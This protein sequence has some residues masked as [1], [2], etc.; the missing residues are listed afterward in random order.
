MTAAGDHTYRRVSAGS[1]PT[2]VVVPG[3]VGTG[4]YSAGQV[5]LSTTFVAEPDLGTFWHI[6]GWVVQGGALYRSGYS[7]LSGQPTDPPFLTRI[8]G[9]WT[10]FKAVEEAE[11]DEVEHAPPV[12]T[13]EYG[14]R[15]D[16]LL[17]R[18]QNNND[19]WRRNAGG[20]GFEAVKVMALISKTRT[21]DTFL[22]TTRGGGLYTIR[23]STAVPAN[24]TVTRVRNSTWQV[25]ETL[26]AVKCGVYGT[27]LL[28][29]DKD[30]QSGYLYAVG[31]ANGLSTV[32]QGLG[33]VQG[34][35]PDPVN[36]RW[37]FDFDP[38]NGA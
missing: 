24:F 6:V 2:M 8:G 5:R 17:V 29:I 19:V 7:V 28:G 31:H 30:T 4:I 18:W 11:Y 13:Y 1:P 25:F 15:N 22:A 34:T 9:G 16:G 10:D 35:F 26:L 3:R 37:R 36:F 32:I 33:K 12:R 21:Y 27:L 20:A 14:L 38:L 23:I